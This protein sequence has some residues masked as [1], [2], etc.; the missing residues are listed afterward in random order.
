M[1]TDDLCF[2][3]AGLRGPVQTG[4]GG[5]NVELVARATWAV[6]EWL[7]TNGSGRTVVVGRDARH[8]SAD[9]FATT[10]GVLAAAGF[11]VVALPGHSPTPLVAFTCR[12]L[13]AAAAIQIT[14]SHNPAGD[15]G[16][17][18]YAG[19]GFDVPGA[20]I[21]SPVD[22]QIEALMAVAPPEIPQVP[23]GPDD[24]EWAATSRYLDRLAT[25][26]GSVDDSLR[27]AL[28]PMH[29]VGG[30]FAVEALANAG[31]DDVHVVDEQF[32][33]DPDF[34]TVDFP[35][36][37]EPGATDLLLRLA[38]RVDAD[39]AIALDPD[40]DRCA[41]AIPDDNRWR[42]LTGDETGAILCHEL[43]VPGAVV[44][45]SIVSGTLAAGV[46]EAAGAR[47]IRTL[48]GFKWLVRAGEPLC[49]AYEEAIGYCVDPDAVRDKDGIGSAVLLAQIAGRL[50]REGSS[51][52]ALLDDLALR[53]GSH[54][55]VGRSLRAT[56][57][58]IAAAMN[59]FRSAPRR[60]LGGVDCVMS[61]YGN[62]DDGLRTDAVEFTGA[63]GDARVHAL[64]RP[65]GTEP[66]AKA[67]VEAVVPVLPQ[68][69]DGLRTARRRA[70]DLACAVADDLFG[71]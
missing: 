15:N 69:D 64:V 55:T 56:P 45:S 31:F 9:F 39:L 33:P 68:D 2:G 42:Q 12:D 36:P 30:R 19:S 66:K 26:F 13:G 67:Y 11:D 58:G 17:K 6:A 21:V 43:A 23:V 5:M 34:P 14:A 28:T 38:H 54:V 48:T 40:A 44:A 51:I 70:T 59:Q 18:L 37:E 22:E 32:A 25:R 65:S 41:I 3:T 1:G 71:R 52:T 10:T 47:S 27:I 62:R 35:N 24:N 57:D 46:A 4:P 63:D 8:G 7:R 49:F 50:R 61:D 60:T 16:Y 53:H 29:G 20:Q